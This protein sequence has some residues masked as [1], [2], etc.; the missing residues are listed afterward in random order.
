MHC[1]API[2]KELKVC[3]FGYTILEQL[4]K[5]ES[6]C[7]AKLEAIERTSNMKLESLRKN[8]RKME[9]NIYR[10]MDE[11]EKAVDEKFK[12]LVEEL[13]DRMDEHNGD[14]AN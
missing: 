3:E 1:K 12:L 10:E 7:D 4:R 9:K 5:F 6:R 2:E 8:I 13:V 14:E 11:R